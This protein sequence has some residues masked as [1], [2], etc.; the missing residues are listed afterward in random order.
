MTS[1][2]YSFDS[3]GGESVSHGGIRVYRRIGVCGLCGAF[4]AGAAL[5]TAAASMVSG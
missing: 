5:V 3:P 2:G 1:G 4:Q